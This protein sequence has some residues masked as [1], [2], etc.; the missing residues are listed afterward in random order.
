MNDTYIL[1]DYLSI[2]AI[3]IIEKAASSESKRLFYRHV[4]PPVQ[5]DVDV[6]IGYRHF[7]PPVQLGAD[8]IF[9][10]R[11]F[12]PLVQLGAIFY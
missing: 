3:N 7:A 9:G 8:V 4:A 10:Y 6:I 5:L 11:Y 1:G 2:K 12:A